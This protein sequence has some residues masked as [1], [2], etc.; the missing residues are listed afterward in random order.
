MCCLVIDFETYYDRTYSLSKLSTPE[1]V[2]DARFEVIGLAVRHPD[3][4]LAF[5]RDAKAA[6]ADLQVEYGPHLRDVTVLYHNSY[7]DDYIMHHHYGISVKR[8]IDTK[9]LAYHVH[10]KRTRNGGVCEGENAGLAALAER[11]ELPVQKGDLGFMLGIRNPSPMQWAEL[12]RYALKDVEITHQ[13]FLRLLP[14]LRRAIF[15]LNIAQHTTELFTRRGIRVDLEGLEELRDRVLTDVSE[16]FAQAGV[17]A[18]QVS[19]NGHFAELLEQALT[20]TNRKLPMKQGKRGPIPATAKTDPAMQQLLEDDDP[21]VAALAG[22]RVGKRSSDQMMARLEKMAAI[23]KA[24]GGEV[25]PMLHYYG[26]HTGRWSGGGGLNLQ[27][28][29]R[30][31][32]GRKIRQLL[33]PRPGHKFVIGDAAQIEARVIAWSAGQTDLVAAFVEGRDIYS[34][35]ASSV[36]GQDVHKPKHDAPDAARLT[37]LRHVGKTATLGLGF[38]LGALKFCNN[39]QADPL[40]A[41]L[42]DDGTLTPA[43]CRGIQKQ[44]R[45][46]YP[47]IPEYWREI[48]EAFTF[49]VYGQSSQQGVR[50]EKTG[51]GTVMIILPSTRALRYPNAR[52]EEQDRTIEYLDDQGQ[53]AT[54]QPQ[55]KSILYGNGTGLYGGKLAENITQAIARDIIA[56]SILRLEERGRRVLLTVHDEIILEVPTGEADA[57]KADLLEELTR[58]PDWGAG[59]PLAAEAAVADRYDK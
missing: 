44:W 5:H 2:H 52:L 10:G 41:P 8:F 29:G 18:E 33:V 26:A 45:G 46:R 39:L 37:A 54:Y 16:W 14:Q 53:I 1:Y 25:P 20:R 42:F 38:G 35:F 48:E 57:A 4:R 59:L 23:A 9:Q 50:F 58:V 6:L 12:E 13:L 17:T 30:S 36:F 21:A 3:G 24:T 55:G 51:D 40:S 32:I 19:K 7:F 43:R 15:E 22:A 31:G 56:E 27:N 49:A 28:M 11:Y 34:E 47:A